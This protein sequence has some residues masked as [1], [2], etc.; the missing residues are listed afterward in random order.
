MK[1]DYPI[2]FLYYRDL[3]KVIPFY[4]DLLGLKLARDQGW[5]KIF[6]ITPGAYV[7]LVDEQVGSLDATDDKGVLLTLVVDDVDAWHEHLLHSDFEVE[8]L[9]SPKLIEDIGVYGFFF[10]DPEGYMI[11]IQK[12]VDEP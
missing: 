6:A 11:E 9:T 1:I 8:S 12:F 7:G 3:E 4:R 2:T 5:C 10:E